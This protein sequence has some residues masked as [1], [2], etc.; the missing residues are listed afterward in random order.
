MF[1]MVF[2]RYEKKY[3][4]DSEKY[5]EVKNYLTYNA[6]P[7]K[8]GKSRV[9][10]LYYD[11]P[12]KRIIRASI[13][14]PVYKEKLRLRSYGLPES[15]KPCFLELKKKYKGVVFKRRISADYRDIL[16]YMRGEIN[17]I[18]ESQILRETDY[19]KRFYGELKP[20][21][22]I[23]YDR[24]AFYDRTDGDVRLTLD[25]NVLARGYDFDLENGIYGERVLEKGL[26]ILEVKTAGAMPVWIAEMLNGLKIYPASFS[27]YGTAYKNGLLTEEKQKIITLGGEY[28]A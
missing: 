25:S 9:C 8:Y 22:D 19:F 14:G 21:A 12:D 2:K 1:Q 6:V 18:P 16:S 23:F 20:T 10:S 17:G 7:D 4:I 11:T 24:E 13:E 5:K 27:K 26:Y 28:C 3:I 15:G